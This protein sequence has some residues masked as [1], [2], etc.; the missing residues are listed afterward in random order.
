[1][2]WQESDCAFEIVD[3][4]IAPQSSLQHRSNTESSKREPI[5]ELASSLVAVPQ[6]TEQ[7]QLTMVPD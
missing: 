4:R 6:R 1:M 3:R 7:S 5:I 2:R